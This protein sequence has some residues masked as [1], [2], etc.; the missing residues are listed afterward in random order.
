MKNLIY[1][2][3]HFETILPYLFRTV[4]GITSTRERVDTPDGDFIDIDWIRVPGS[5][6]T[7]YPIPWRLRAKVI[8][9][10]F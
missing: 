3:G 10:T 8:K 7:S 1:P 6:K 2:I 9:P 4:K 5:K